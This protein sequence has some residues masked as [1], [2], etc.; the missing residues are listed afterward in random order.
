MTSLV[1][2]A[3][4]GLAREVL[5]VE[6]Q[7]GRYDEVAI[8]DDNRQLWG[9]TVGG[10]TVIGPVEVAAEPGNHDIVV[11]AGSGVVRRG[12]VRRLAAMGISSSRYA[13]VIHPSVVLPVRCAIG[14]GAILLGGVVLTTDVSLHRHVV[15]MP[16]VTLTHD[17]VVHD[18]ATLCAGVSLG[19]EVTV[20]E[21]A[22]L[23]M[24]SSV[25]QGLQVGAES[26]LGMG[27]A[28]LRDLPPGE[29]WVGVPARTIRD[30]Q[31]LAL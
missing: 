3:A 17:D 14:A 1:V 16:Q 8:V 5:A 29:T 28:L 10:A 24:N 20:G 19:G 6:E 26:T 22:Y 11:C 15:A 13:R 2:V 7:L 23:G 30:R 12:L 25:R 18:F 4:S 21:A 27:A 31:E 9:R